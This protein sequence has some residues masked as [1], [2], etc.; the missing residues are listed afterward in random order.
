MDGKG[1]EGNETVEKLETENIRGEFRC[2]QSTQG[3]NESVM[4]EICR[5]S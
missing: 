4:V 5:G 2:G 3:G 1:I